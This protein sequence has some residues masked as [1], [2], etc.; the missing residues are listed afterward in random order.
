[1]INYTIEQSNISNYEKSNYDENGKYYKMT[2]T[3]D[4]L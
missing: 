3:L 4:K 1:M 2:L